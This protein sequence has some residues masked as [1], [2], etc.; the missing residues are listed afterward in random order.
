MLYFLRQ[1]SS[2]C[3]VTIKRHRKREEMFRVADIK[4]FKCK[5][6]GKVYQHQEDDKTINC[7]D[8]CQNPQTIKGNKKYTI[9]VTWEVYST[10]EVEASSKEE[11]LKEFYKIEGREGGGF[12]L[13]KEAYYVDDS[14]NTSC[15]GDE[16]L[17]MIKEV[18]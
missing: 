6:G 9:P 14:F 8:S 1:K 2:I 18:S 15:E 3:I 10:V 4:S 11:A 17:D 12:P 13:P 5:C 16:L 7:C